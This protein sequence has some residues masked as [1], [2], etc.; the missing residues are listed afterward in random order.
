MTERFE[1][2]LTGA[3]PYAGDIEASGALHLAFVRSPVA[4]GRIVS[5]ETAQAAT[6]P[7]VVAVFRPGD[8]DAGSRPPLSGSP[9]AMS[10]PP[11]AD[12][13]VRY[14]GE[15]VVAVLAESPAAAADAVDLVS[16]D[17]ELLPSVNSVEDALSPQSPRLF[18]RP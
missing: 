7:G 5:L 14:V 11:L 15:P 1:G 18:P 2:L 16:V 13:I 17:Y 8:L 3:T 6:A 9:A 10:Q 12:G 4:H